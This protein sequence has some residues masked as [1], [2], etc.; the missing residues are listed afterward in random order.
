LDSEELIK[1]YL[2]VHTIAL[3]FLYN[4]HLT[5]LIWTQCQTSLV[6]ELDMVRK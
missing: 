2:L 3:T 6:Q 1:I 4:S 5:W